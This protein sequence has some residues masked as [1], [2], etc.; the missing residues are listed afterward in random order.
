MVGVKYLSLEIT[1]YCNLDCKHCMQGKK[2]NVYMSDEVIRKTFK[3][4]NR[5]EEL[6]LTG[7][8]VFLCYERVKRVLEIAHEENVEILNCSIVTN[9]CVYDERIYDLLDSYFGY[10][11]AIYISNDDYHDKS[12]LRNYQGEK[13]SNNP[14][15]NPQTLEEVKRNMLKHM[16]RDRFE[17]F[18]ELGSRLI[19]VGRARNIE[20]SKHPFEVMGYFYQ[21]FSECFL[22]G[23]IVFVSSMGYVCEGN[24]EI[25]SYEKHSIGNILN[26]DIKSMVRKGGIEMHFSIPEEFFHFLGERIHNYDTLAGPHYHIIDGKMVEVNLVRD[27]AYQEELKRFMELLE[28]GPLTLNKMLAYDFSKYPYDLSLIEHVE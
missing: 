19:D 12:I 24:D 1:E 14:E 25:D 28:D 10:Y 27:N 16:E 18:K 11:Y 8:E 6:V 21:E 7:G 3:S 5:V 4:I 23:P 17:D 13:E 20:G 26:E 9:G 22:I 15:L 2:C